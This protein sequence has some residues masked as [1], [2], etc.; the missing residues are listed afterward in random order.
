MD[1]KSLEENGRNMGH[2]IPS[3][4]YSNQILETN[5]LM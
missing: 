5:Q 4:I 3:L 2:Q 1:P